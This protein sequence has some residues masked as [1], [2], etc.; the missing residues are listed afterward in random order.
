MTPL[1]YLLQ[2]GTA[3]VM[4]PLVIGHFAVIIIAV[5]GGLSAEEILAR[6]RGNLGWGLFY[7]L[8]VLA[9]AIHA[10]I[11]MQAILREWLSMPAKGAAIAGHGFMLVLMLLGA[12]AIYG[13]VWS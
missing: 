9:A 6:T 12:A 1:A 5:Q 4:L 7:G 3:A 11:G 10:G 2:R 13:V 8:F